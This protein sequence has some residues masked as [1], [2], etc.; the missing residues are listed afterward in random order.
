MRKPKIAF[1][2]VTLKM[3]WN[4]YPE[5]KEKTEVALNCVLGRL[6]EFA[7]VACCGL[8]GSID[9]ALDSGDFLRKQDCDI[10]VVWTNGYVSSDIPDIV[11]RYLHGIPVVLLSTQ[12]DKNVPQGM[13]YVRYW[14]NSGL[15]GIV[16]L[17]GAL[18]KI[19]RPYESLVG[20]HDEAPL[21][22]RLYSM[23]QA[24]VVR[25]SLQKLRIGILGRAYPGMQDILID[26]RSLAMIGVIALHI[27]L[28]EIDQRL[29]SL[30]A[31][32]AKDF[33]KSTAGL[34][35]ST[36]VEQED[37]V[38]AAKLYCVL[39]DIVV[40]F[41]LDAL[42]VHDYECLSFV[43]QTV[44]ELALSLLEKNLGLAV[45]CEGDIPNTISAFVSR[46]FSG[47]SPMFVDW[48]MFDQKRNAVY[49]VHNGKADPSI[50]DK[51]VLKPTAEPF[52]IVGKGAV[53]EAAGKAGN[54][55]MLSLIFD[56]SWKLFV[57]EGEALSSPAQPCSQNQITVRVDMPV[58]KYLE[59][60]IN[61][62]VTHHVN[63]GYGHYANKVETL[64]KFM[65][66]KCVRI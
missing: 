30:N 25:S 36:Y 35:D 22:E 59:Q 17:G 54:V 14:E 16:E 49:F 42:C 65:G 18:S 5:I 1:I 39:Q 4:L 26:E 57:S 10:A 20:L 64:A 51:P 24:A 13:D 2:P 33:L 61:S 60:V 50:I 44:S 66:F 29:K 52:G 55:T 28:P 47:M 56:T 27:S 34:F 9:E 45:G 41:K 43:S 31:A 21:Y 23:T 12:L 11:L 58:R 40:E 46:A 32:A 7:D 48:G 8:T 6:H 3:F 38:R 19:N 37:L 63:I 15:T 53:F 62:G